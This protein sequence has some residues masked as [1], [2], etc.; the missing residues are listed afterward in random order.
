MNISAVDLSILIVYL[1]G[2][3]ALGLWIGRGQHTATEY[4][5]GGRD[6]PWVA[7]L[8]SIV[9]TET[10]TVT[11]LSVPGYTFDVQGDRLRG[12]MT[13]LQLSFGYIIGRLV[14]VWLFLPLFFEGKLFTSYE[15]LHRRFG[16]ATK[17]VASLLFLITRN[18]ADGLR[19]YLTAI[20]LQKFLGWNL[21]ACVVVIGLFTIVYTVAGGLRSVV[22]NDC[23]QFFVYL[24]GGVLVLVIIAG[25][26][27]DGWAELLKFGTETGKL[28]VFDLSWSLAGSY[29]L[30]AGV[31]GG[32]FLTLATHGTDQMMVQRYLGARSQGQAALALGL[33]G[34]VV[35]AQFVLF[36]FVGVALAWFY[37]HVRPSAS[38]DRSDE[39]LA[40][41]IVRE[42]PIGAIGI[43]LAAVFAAAMSTLSSSLSSSASAVVNDFFVP[44]CRTRPSE[45]T[46]VRT[47]RLMTGVFGVVQIAVGVAGQW[48]QREVVTN[49]LSIA[50]LTTGVTLGLFFLAI[51]PRRVSQ[52]AALV[53]FVAGF[54]VVAYVAFNGYLVELGVPPEYTFSVGWPWYA[55]IGSCSVVVIGLV[56]ELAV[57]RSEGDR[58]E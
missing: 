6:L 24:A 47:S 1:L 58:N 55:V 44:A 48:T 9:A 22:W 30:W 49:V 36:L 56:A 42:M 54:A 35:A 10:S 51:V 19:L 29:T 40:T 11:F 33:S 50:G 7:V 4:L 14:I 20:V 37:T 13:F 39:V 41:F 26:A 31:I 45:T 52:R 3:V 28:Q 27:P 18:V 8:L 23:L 43:T 21:A 53:G 2:V 57:G 32:L 17:Q 16:G 15:V 34:L 25:H 12:D 5:L 46:L 38:F